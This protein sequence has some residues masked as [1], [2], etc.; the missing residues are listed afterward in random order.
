[1][2]RRLFLGAMLAA[3][4]TPAIVRAGSLMRINPKIITPTTFSEA[5]LTEATLEDMLIYIMEFSLLKEH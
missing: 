1:M 3:S 4:A 5:I 2:N